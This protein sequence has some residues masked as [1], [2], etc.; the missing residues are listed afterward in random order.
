MMSLFE[1]H[2]D[3]RRGNAVN[4]FICKCQD[5]ISG[6]LT[7]FDRLVLRGQLSLNHEPGMKGYLWANGVAWKDYAKHVEEVSR[8]VKQA[9][10]APME[11]ENRPVRYLRSAQQSKEEMARTIAR[12]DGVRQGPVCAFTAVEPCWSWRVAGNRETPKLQLLRSKR[13]CLFVYHYWIDPVFGFL[14][15]RLQTWFPFTVYVYMNGREWLAQ[16]MDEA[17]GPPATSRSPG[18]SRARRR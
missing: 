15:A 13:Q 18:A 11:A 12:E 4:D 5:A 9:S 8:R 16:Q 14:S 2:I 3:P 17:R 1:N 7:G 10:L 6:V